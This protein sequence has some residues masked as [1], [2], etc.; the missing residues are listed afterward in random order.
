MT[1]R[2][3]SEIRERLESLTDDERPAR[4]FGWDD[5]LEIVEA[6]VAI[7]EWILEK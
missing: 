3:E 7:L 6:K 4:R 2:S 1:M 5:E